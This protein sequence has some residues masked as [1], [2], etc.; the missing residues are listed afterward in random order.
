M[1]VRKEIK[2]LAG[3]ENNTTSHTEKMICAAGVFVGVMVVYWISAGVLSEPTGHTLMV[4][5]LGASVVL[6]FATPHGALSQPWPVIAGNVISAAIGVACYKHIPDPYLGAA[7]AVSLSVAAMHY[8]R[9][10]HPPGG[11]TAL[12]A[13]IGGNEIHDVGYHYVL[14][15]VL[16]NVVA[17]VLV[18]VLFNLV[19]SWRRYPAHLTRRHKKTAETVPDKIEF[20]LTQEDFAAA[21]QQM[22]SY[23]DV[24]SDGLTELLELAKQHA[25]T[26][27]T[28]PANIEAGLFYSNGR[29]GRSWSVR[30]VVAVNN[31]AN[32]DKATVTYQTVA[33]HGGHESAT[34]PRAK[35]LQ[36]ARFEVAQ[37]GGRWVKVQAS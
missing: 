12:T 34:C 29:I 18:A 31:I 4:A 24:T 16:I 22:D 26:H 33:G 6:L 15:P 5:S 32:P 2:A 23:I 35:F 13:V 19:F 9:C 3:I 30:Q 36:W 20:E 11:A 17:I 10:L 25:E 37:E 27:K 7:T 1:S 8:L 21:M 28:Q 14:N